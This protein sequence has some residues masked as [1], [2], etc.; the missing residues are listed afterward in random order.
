MPPATVSPAHRSLNVA[1]PTVLLVEDDAGDAVLV[2]EL[3]SDA[4]DDFQ[5]L[6]VRTLAEAQQAMSPS[7]ACVLFDLGL[8]DAEGIE[9]LSAMLAIAAGIPV[10]VLTGLGDREKGSEAVTIGAQD[11]LLKG[12]VDGETLARSIRYAVERGRLQ[13]AQ[14]QLLEA[15]LRRAENARLQRAL[16]PRP[17]ISTPRLAWASR[18]RPGGR[19]A[20]LGGDFYDAVELAD[21]RVRAVIGDVCGHGPDEAALGVALR[22]AWRA[23]ILAGVAEDEVLPALQRVLEAERFA[24]HIF[25]TVCDVTIEPGLAA[26]RIRLAGH[27]A[28]L[29]LEDGTVAPV[30]V[31]RPGPLLG[32]IDE[33]DWASNAVTLGDQWTLLLYTDGITETRPAPDQERLGEGGLTDLTQRLFDDGVDLDVFADLLLG[34]VAESTDGASGDDVALFLLSAGRRAE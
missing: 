18:Y 24:P 10:V 11:Y 13:A 33:A 3:L 8:P 16:L 28:P 7:V 6:T 32:V 25:A 31:A 19:R 30:V 5:L 21:G 34:S 9:G 12:H 22:V 14:Q 2:R 26:G 1:R 27:P 15:T 23:Q 20:L 4:G 29:L 17:L